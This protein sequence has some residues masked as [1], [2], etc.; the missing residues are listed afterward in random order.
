MCNLHK[1][2][3]GKRLMTVIPGEG[4]KCDQGSIKKSLNVIK[5]KRHN[6]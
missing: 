2:I 1:N 4:R 3:H 5:E 6:E